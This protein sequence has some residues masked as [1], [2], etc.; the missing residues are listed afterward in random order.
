M[1]EDYEQMELDTRKEL[2]VA[3]TD[4]TADAINTVQDMILRCGEAPQPVHNRHEA[5]GIAA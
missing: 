3:I 5:Y 1:K 2:D 4:L